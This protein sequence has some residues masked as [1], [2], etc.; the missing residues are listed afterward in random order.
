MN[1]F[2]VAI[3]GAGPGGYIAALRAAQQ[4]LKTC[5]VE[6]DQVGGVCLNRG[7]IPTKT[8]LESAKHIN[9]LK[10]ASEFG[11]K[12]SDF[13]IDALRI[14][15]R[16]NQVVE[17][18]R[19]GIEY[20]FKARGVNF[21][22]GEAK[23]VANDT[24][25]VKSDSGTLQLKAKN[26]ILATGSSP[27]EL[28]DLK[29]DHKL[30]LSSDDILDLSRIPKS[31]IIVGGGV[32]G[33]EFASL[34]SSLGTSITIVELMENLLSLEDRE[35]SK[36][37]E[38]SFK[39]KGIGIKTRTKLES[40]KHKEIGVE[41]CLSDGTKINSELILVCVGRKPNADILGLEKVK[42]KAE[43]KGGWIKVDDCLRTNVENVYA[44]GDVTGKILLAHVAS[45][46]AEI[47]VENILGHNKQI[48]YSA[49]PNCI[50]TF[51]E[52]SS[53]GISEA[54][55]KEL[56]LDYSIAKFPFRVLGKSHTVGETE[57]FL[58]LLI[59]RKTELILGAHIIG[60]DAT[61]LI[62][63]LTLAMKNKLKAGLITETIH[64]HPTFSEII[65]ETVFSFLNI[66]LHTV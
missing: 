11:I 16:K 25:E 38:M 6:K 43:V 20:L 61:G 26:I 14:W 65:P 18:L 37:L 7:C 4:G 17:N 42:V 41:A 21:I 53:V 23:L 31:L 51:P 5:V 66:P 58:K 45:R 63:E 60:P 22:K 50:F 33:C 2:D 30:I 52:V 54:K 3:I 32:I 36:T 40:V 55:A 34:F 56:N 49:V 46:Q 44:I 28:P 27:F 29:F 8:L 47:A 1:E 9:S 39:K 59:D 48:D 57:G 12:V 24:V 19:K 35:I 13:Q 62:A 10:K 15:Q 64:A